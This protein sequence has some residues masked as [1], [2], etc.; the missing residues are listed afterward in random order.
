MDKVYI[1]TEGE[2]SDY[3]VCGVFTSR[4]KAEKFRDTF[5]CNDTIEEYNLNPYQKQ[6]DERLKPSCICV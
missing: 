1:V 4:E 3:H 2:Y 6:I 5:C